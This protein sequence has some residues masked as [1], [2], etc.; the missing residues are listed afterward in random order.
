MAALKSSRRVE[1][2]RQRLLESLLA[3]IVERGYEKVTVQ[4]ILDR[5]EA[6]RATFYQHFRSKEDLLKSGL[7]HMRALLLKDWKADALAGE[8]SSRQL[9]FAL[10][11]FRHMD[12]RRPLYRAIMARESGMIVERKMRRIL[13]DFVREDLRSRTSPRQNP[14]ARDLAVQY[15]VGALWTVMSWWLDYRV[16]LAP[17]EIDGLFCQLTLPGLDAMLGAGAQQTGPT[18]A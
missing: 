11:L 3:L 13:A 17:E 2:T 7:D 9:G 15:V 1:R 18:L 5:A 14:V 10:A 6:G 4:D 16:P 12:G 8:K